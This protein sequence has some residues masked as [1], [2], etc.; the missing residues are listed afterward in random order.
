[1]L[2]V[3]CRAK[4]RSIYPIGVYRVLQKLH[5]SRDIW[6]L[7]VPLGINLYGAVDALQMTTSF[8]SRTDFFSVTEANDDYNNSQLN[9]ICIID[10]APDPF[11]KR[12]LNLY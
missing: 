4:P 5:E 11:S 9:K 8:T 1:M 2:L 10:T 3:E 12:S 6:L 7:L